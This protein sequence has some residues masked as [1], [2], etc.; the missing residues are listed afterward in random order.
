MKTILTTLFLLAAATAQAQFFI[1]R[2]TVGNSTALDAAGNV[3]T[4]GELKDTVDFDPGAGVHLLSAGRKFDTHLNGLYVSKLDATGAFVWAKALGDSAGGQNMNIALDPAGNIYISGSFYSTQDFD[5]GAGTSIFTSAG[6]ADIFVLKMDGT[7]NLLWAQRIGGSNVDFADGIAVDAGGNVYIT[8]DFAGTVDFDPGTG[9]SNLSSPSA[10]IRGAYLAKLDATGAFVWAKQPAS[11]G[12]SLASCIALNAAGNVYVGGIFTGTA[13]FDPGAAVANKTS[14]GATDAFI[15][16]LD[17]AGNYVWAGAIGGPGASIYEETI[18]SLAADATGNLYACGKSFGTSDYDP[19]A[20]STTLGSAPHSFVVKLDNGNAFLWAKPLVGNTTITSVKANTSGV[21][22]IGNARSG[23]DFN[24]GTATDTFSANGSFVWKLDAAGAY[25]WAVQ[26]VPSRYYDDITTGSGQ[27]L[28]L[29]AS[30]NVH[31][32]GSFYDTADFDPG[33]ATFGMTG[34]TWNFSVG[35]QGRAAYVLKLTSTGSFIWAKQFNGTYLGTATGLSTLASTGSLMLAPV[36][37][38]RIST[39][40][41]SEPLKDA[42]IRLH[43][44]QGQVVAIWRGVSDFDFPMDV[45]GLATGMYIVE[46][47]QGGAAQRL[48]LVKQ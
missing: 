5:P 32:T 16:A 22:A 9:V 31:L 8:G 6:G 1:P 2:T 17:A 26:F 24:P 40:H 28:Q 4:I 10:S 35:N 29:D 30:G 38:E 34:P 44:M 27:S 14:S 20:G 45:S 37:S 13:D 47:Q 11:S 19:G 42:T 39:L 12:N 48:R 33:I 36:P 15:W 21:F 46:V 7:G 43:T 18:W 3:Y 41:S 25:G 23:V